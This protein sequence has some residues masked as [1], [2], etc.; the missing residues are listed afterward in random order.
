MTAEVPEAL[1]AIGATSRLDP[2]P[3]LVS[4]TMMSPGFILAVYS[5]SSPSSACFPSSALSMML[6]YFPGMIT[7]VST[8]LPYL[9]AWPRS[10]ASMLHR[11]RFDDARIGYSARKRRCG[12]GRRRSEEDLCLGRAH[13]PHVVS[14]GS[15]DRALAVAERAH[16]PAET[17]TAAR[18]VDGAAGGRKRRENALVGGLHPNLLRARIHDHAD[19][20]SDS[21]T[22]E[23]LCDHAQIVDV[24]IRTRAD[25]DLIDH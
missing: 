17:G 6:Q 4:A 9:C 3:K 16:V 12:A 14:I 20:G 8:F 24:A 13:P 22:V 2:Q 1:I 21:L 18:R 19:V 15:R 11:H 23:D 5:G 7:S 25:E 10:V